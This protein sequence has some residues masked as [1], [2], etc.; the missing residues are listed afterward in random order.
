MKRGA[1]TTVVNTLYPFKQDEDMRALKR[2]LSY[3]QPLPEIH[4]NK[5]FEEGATY[6]R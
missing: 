3:D 1:F 2:A 4:Y 6:P 5:L